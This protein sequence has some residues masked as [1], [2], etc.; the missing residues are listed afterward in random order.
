MLNSE[1]QNKERQRTDA[2][3]P[4]YSSFDNIGKL[5]KGKTKTFTVLGLK[6]RYI[7]YQLKE[8]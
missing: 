2:K 7:D 3:T 1:N 5:E 6:I 4:E 8:I